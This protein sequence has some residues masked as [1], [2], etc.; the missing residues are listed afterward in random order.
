MS[1]NRLWSKKEDKILRENYLKDVRIQSFMRLL[2][3]REYNAIKARANLLGMK[4]DIP[5]EKDE[6][7]FEV[8][9][10]MNCAVAGFIAADGHIS[11][12]K[13]RMTINL[14]IK[15][16]EHLEKI[17]KLT[18]YAGPLYFNAAQK[19]VRFCKNGEPYFCDSER[20]CVLSVSC[21][22]WVIDLENN[23]NITKQKTFTL[24]GPNLTDLKLR[25]AFISGA[26]DGD[27]WICEPM[28]DPNEIKEYSLSIMGNLDFIN[29]VRNVFDGISINIDDG[30]ADLKFEGSG[31]IYSFKI[32]GTKLYWIAKMFFTLDI[33]RLDRKWDKMKKLINLVESSHDIPKKRRTWLIKMCPSDDVM[34]Q[35]GLLDHKIEMIEK[36][37]HKKAAF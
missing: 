24:Q 13:N 7:F 33:I 32:S 15:D 2:P 27:G 17:Q 11:K 5:Y 36:L 14:S 22:K 9:N 3:K 30:R 26:I 29:W 6:T 12:T 10:Q 18:G 37:G 31:S 1:K 20:K 19:N 34:S 35:F 4:R 28:D 25:L 8:P 16:Q 21:P 23:W